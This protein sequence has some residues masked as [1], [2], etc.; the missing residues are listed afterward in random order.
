M[1][2]TLIVSALIFSLISVMIPV[3][4]S[5]DV[6]LN[7]VQKASETK[8]LE[9]DQGYISKT[10]VDSDSEKGEVTVEVKLSNTSKESVN[11]KRFDNSEIFII[12]P[13]YKNAQENE[14]LTYVETLAEKIFAKNSKIKIGVIGIQGTIADNS[15]DEKGNQIKG[16][17]DQADVN[18]TAD[19][20]ECIVELTQDISNF[21]T[22]LRKMNS[23]KIA[24]YPNFQAAIR[25]A[26]NS[27]SDKTNKILISLYDNVPS[28]S[29][30]TN[31]SITYGGLFSQYGT[32]EEAVK[33]YLE[34]LVTKTKSEILSLKDSNID[35]ILL[36]PD[37]TGFDQ[38]FYSTTTG[39]LIC[40]IDGKPYADNLYGTL[41]KPTY[42]KM[43]SLNN[44]SLEKIVTENI[45]QDIMEKVRTPI[46]TIKI[47][48]YFPEEIVK[49]FD[50]SYVA[51]PNI[52]TVSEKIDEKNTITWD[53]EKLEAD[54]VAT[55]QYKLKIKDMSKNSPIYNKEIAT[56]EKIVLTYKD[57]NEK[58]YEVTLASSPKIKLENAKKE[59]TL[60]QQNN[61]AKDTSVAN[62][63]LPKAGKN[64]I[65]ISISLSIILVIIG[66]KKYNKYRD[67]K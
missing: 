66:V 35:F 31:S 34:E 36:R 32:A 63:I 2:K 29:I 28:I 57:L 23:E 41:E 21:K 48:D 30:G 24:Y 37:D 45:Y 5:N 59:A 51:K 56:N 25:L 4:A 22:K 19:N 65:I 1:K 67:I 60:S 7:I 50:F 64:I 49:N 27:F 33:A 9:N 11:E 12:V 62:K 3:Y 42:G 16:E 39:E 8:Y 14:K 55:L 43:Y 38:K 40:N 20:A 17:K 44:E 18:G 46:T 26:K 15:Y 10:I 6:A 47:I 13:E 58:D 52:G 53:I 54:E 61:T